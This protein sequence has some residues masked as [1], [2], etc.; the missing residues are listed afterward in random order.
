MTFVELINNNIQLK[1]IIK[2]TLFRT[3]IGKPIEYDE[4]RTA[5]ELK[6]LVMKNKKFN[7]YSFN[8]KSFFF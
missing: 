5:D 4:S 8:K 2:I 1:I 7:Y 6:A 3:Y